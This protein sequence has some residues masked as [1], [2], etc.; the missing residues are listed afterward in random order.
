MSIGL[1]HHI[2]SHPL[3]HGGDNVGISELHSN[4]LSAWS[5]E[6]KWRRVA[7]AEVSSRLVH[8]CHMMVSL[9]YYSIW[10]PVTGEI[11]LKRVRTMPVLSNLFT[12]GTWTKKEWLYL[13]KKWFKPK[14][15]EGG[16]PCL[17]G[18]ARTLPYVQKTRWELILDPTHQ[19]LVIFD[20]FK[21]QTTAEFLKKLTDNNISVVSVPASWTDRLQPLDISVNKPL[22]SHMRNSFQ[23]WYWTKCKGIWLKMKPVHDQ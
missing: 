9:L 5:P 7:V 22:K 17:K 2:Q 16:P 12:Q 21:A 6:N 14:F 10:Y 1:A 23:Q 19:A 18:L 8:S 13:K 20:Q 4:T 15:K 3:V 11:R